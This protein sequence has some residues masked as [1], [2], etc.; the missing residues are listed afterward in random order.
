[1]RKTRTVG[2]HSSIDRTRPGAATDPTVG[3]IGDATPSIT[4]GPLNNAVN[5]SRGAVEVDVRRLPTPSDDDAAAN[6]RRLT[7]SCTSPFYPYRARPGDATLAPPTTA[8]V[9]NEASV[10]HR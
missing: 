6:C 5:A 9:A 7:G 1:M 8:E 10:L 2:P 3:G 4:V